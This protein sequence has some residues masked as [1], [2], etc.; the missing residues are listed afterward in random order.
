MTMASE[1]ERESQARRVAAAAQ[2][3]I[4][5][6]EV[7]GWL[8]TVGVGS[9]LTLGILA[10]AAAL[11]LMIALVAEVAIPLA[12]AAVLAAV[13]VPLTDRLERW[14]VPRWLGAT[15]VLVLGLSIV[16]ATI[17]LVINGISSQG[18]A[19]WSRL[20]AGLENA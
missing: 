5:A 6:F 13:L 9:W 8:R 16:A 20:E 14:R 19:I 4:V 1:S 7:P 11:L 12:I 3:E 18:A 2:R 15:L 10:L 17:A